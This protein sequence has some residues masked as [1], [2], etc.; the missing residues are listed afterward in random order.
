MA[1]GLKGTTH[2]LD[3]KEKEMSDQNSEF[4]YTTY[5]KDR[6]L[7]DGKQGSVEIKLIPVGKK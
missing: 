1:K 4:E 7:K 3:I 2:N 6:I 5:T